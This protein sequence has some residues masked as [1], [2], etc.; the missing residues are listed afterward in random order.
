MNNRKDQPMKILL[1]STTNVMFSG[2]SWS[3]LGMAE[4]FRKM[5]HNVVV[6]LPKGRTLEEA[7]RNRKLP[8]KVI[9]QYRAGWCQSI[10]DVPKTWKASMK[11][12]A[13]RLVNV[14]AAFQ[15]KQY[16]QKENFDIVHVNAS[17]DGLAGRIA[18]QNGM[19][20]VWH[21]REFMEEDLRKEFCNPTLALQT[22][23]Q[24]SAVIAISEAVKK[25]Y[26][27]VFGSK[28]E[29]VYNGIDIH[30]FIAK[31]DILQNDVTTICIAGRISEAKGQEQLIRAVISILKNSNYRIA[32]QII[33]TPQYPEYLK[34]LKKII[35]ES[36][37]EE[38]YQF[39]G[40]SNT[41]EDYYK[42]ADIV[43]VC[44]KK[45]AFGRVTVEGMASGAVVIGANT[46]GTTEL[47]D[48]Q[49]TGL[50]YEEG[51]P[52]S[53]AEQI[54]W[55]IRNKEEARAVALRGQQWVKERFTAENNGKLNRSVRPY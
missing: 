38:A 16:L 44:S 43:C 45:E 47:I 19:H 17:T 55:V 31:R 36:G 26:A 9:V 37:Y 11:E 42:K 50:L 46:G 1:V 40:F 39:I 13:Q 32:V 35:S 27:N 49:S 24:A 3:L 34:K 7:C 53:L 21:I 6:L 15:I 14:L 5:G 10:S 48:H 52:L 23:N 29:V 28:L 33:G 4:Y 54:Q 22:M 18:V 12:C 25:K 30:K 8:Y 51:D 41:V 20:V 2:A